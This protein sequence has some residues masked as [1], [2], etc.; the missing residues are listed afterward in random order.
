MDGKSAARIKL[1]TAFM[2]A[3]DIRANRFH[4]MVDGRSGSTVTPDIARK[5]IQATCEEV[6]DQF[7]VT[8]RL[9]LQWLVARS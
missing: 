2:L 6:K 4:L 9:L 5:N 1:Q 7:P 8:T 3:R